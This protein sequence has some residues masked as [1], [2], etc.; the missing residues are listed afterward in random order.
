M[1]VIKENKKYQ[2]NPDWYD[3]FAHSDINKV[4]DELDIIHETFGQITADN[5][6][7]SAKNKK[8]A[9]HSYFEWDDKAAA[10]KFRIKQ[11][12]ILLSNIQVVVIKD[13]K[14]KTLRAFETITRATKENGIVVQSIDLITDENI[15]R[16]VRFSIGDLRRISNRL[17]RFDKFNN[18]VEKINKVAIMLEHE[19]SKESTETKEETPVLSAV[20]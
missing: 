20:V 14:P 1:T 9:L 5:I 3:K 16:I 12:A 18:A 2:F 6:V 4:V 17:S 10:H 13:G 15:E 8:S 19:L 11:A 7:A